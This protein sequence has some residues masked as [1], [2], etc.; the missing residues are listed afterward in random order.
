VRIAK[1]MTASKRRAQA[2]SASQKDTSRVSSNDFSGLIYTIRDEGE[3]YRK[4]ERNEETGK[5]I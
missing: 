2:A 1:A 5:R 3:A 4:E